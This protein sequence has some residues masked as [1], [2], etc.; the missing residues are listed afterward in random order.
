MRSDVTRL[1][2][3]PITLW[4]N[5]GLCL[6]TCAAAIILLPTAVGAQGGYDTT[7]GAAPE[8]ALDGNRRDASEYQQQRTDE[9]GQNGGKVY[10]PAQAV[11]DV[12]KWFSQYDD[13]RKKY[14]S[15]PE[16]RAYFNQL[17]SKPP[18][19]GLNDDERKFLYDMAQ[20]YNEA[21]N[22][23]REVEGCSETQHLHRGYGSFLAQQANVCIDYIQILGQPNAV[24]RK[25]GRP[26]S[27]TI[28]D[29]RRFLYNLEKANQALDTKTR[30]IFN[31]TRNP[32]E[33]KEN[34]GS[35]DGNQ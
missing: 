21:F 17:V 6:L 25:T 1:L 29:K 11:N 34:D 26:L 4:Q 9:N 10:Q 3:L 14:E 16:E 31:V 28:G 24:D 5:G 33:R 22:Q 12:D 27:S 18:G 15:T 35:S 20:R 23:M 7:D 13:I 30:E 2:K 8:E 32:Y 19:S